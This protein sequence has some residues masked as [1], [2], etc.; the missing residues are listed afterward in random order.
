MSISPNNP[1]DGIPPGYWEYLFRRGGGELLGAVHSLKESRQ[2]A[3]T[4]NYVENVTRLHEKGLVSWFLYKYYGLDPNSDKNIYKIENKPY[5]LYIKPEWLLAF[6]NPSDVLKYPLEN[7]PDNPP[8]QEWLNYK[9]KYIERLHEIGRKVY[10]AQTFR[11]I[12]VEQHH[13]RF[14]LHCG[15]GA[16]YDFLATCEILSDELLIELSKRKLENLLIL[17]EPNVDIQQKRLIDDISKNLIARNQFA[18]DIESVL[19]YTARDLKIGLDIFLVMNT[20]KNRAVCALYHRAKD[21]G[22]YPDLNHVMPAGTF[23]HDA[24]RDLPY[25]QAMDAYYIQYKVLSELWEECFEG[26]DYKSQRKMICEARIDLEGA[27]IEDTDLFPIKDMMGLLGKKDAFLYVTGFG[28]DLFSAKPD[29]SLLLV[30][31]NPSFWEKYKDNFK[32]NWEF[33]GHEKGDSSKE[34]KFF[35]LYDEIDEIRKYIRPGYV[36]PIGAMAVD[37]GIS[38]LQM[39]QTRRQVNFNVPKLV[40]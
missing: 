28:I 30:V 15:L 2:K 4:K 11:L 32:F 10:D 1:L 37:R 21:I 3:K 5:H 7:A 8:S 26:A 40:S 25:E 33:P 23:Q 38:A 35:Y 39:L 9:N 29:L 16:Y 18:P 12:N 34:V 22:E 14:E 6:M 36:I 31:N 27:Q 20:N 24:T 19:N 17:T 13:D